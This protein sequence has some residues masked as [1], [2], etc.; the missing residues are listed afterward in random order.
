[1]SNKPQKQGRGNGPDGGKTLFFAT[2]YKPWETVR[3][4]IDTCAGVV[5]FNRQVVTRVQLHSLGGQRLKISDFV[6]KVQGFFRNPRNK[7]NKG[8]LEIVVGG[9]PFAAVDKRDLYNSL[10]RN[11]ETP[12]DGLVSILEAEFP[13]EIADDRLTITRVD[14]KQEEESKKEKTGEVNGTPVAA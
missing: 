10:R 9:I 2:G 6:S 14:S 1:M 11:G 3:S 5:P 7:K 4:W 12:A 13:R 8:V